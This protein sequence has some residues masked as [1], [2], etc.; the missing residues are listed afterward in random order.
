MEEF[1]VLDM[2]VRCDLDELD[3]VGLLICIY[4][5]V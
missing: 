4:G 2:I 5:G 1:D 3:K